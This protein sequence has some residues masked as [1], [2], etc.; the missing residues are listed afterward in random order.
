[1]KTMM[2]FS[3]LFLAEHQLIRRA[4]AVLERMAEQAD[5]GIYADR[6]DI[7]ALL[8]FLHYFV[9]AFHQTK[10]ESILFPAL[11]QAGS[12]QSSESAVWLAED[13]EHLLREHTEDRFL[14]DRSQLLLFS[15]K[16]Q[17]FA[18]N[19]KALAGLLSKHAHHEEQY[20]FPTA[21]K[22]FNREQGERVAMGM[23]QAD[24]QFGESQ[25]RLLVDML[26]ELERKYITK[27]A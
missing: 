4:V 17:E 27:A 12:V 3:E 9:D 22:I 2:R 21:E 13:I 24:A 26:E 18:E 11:R 5:T 6:H 20:L 15:E 16:S 14:I 19:A 23:E 7:N 25:K 1:M 10:E 8:I